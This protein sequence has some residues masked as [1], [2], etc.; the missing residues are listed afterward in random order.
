M[1]FRVSQGFARDI[2][3]AH[4]TLAPEDPGGDG[5]PLVKPVMAGRHGPAPQLIRLPSLQ[6]ETQH[7]I[8]MLGK[9]RAAG[10][11][12]HQMAVLYAAPFIGEKVA[13]AFTAAGIPL[14]WLKDS[15]SKR[16]NASHPSI[17]LMHLKSSNG[18]EF[19]VVAIA[20]VGHLP[21]ES[22]VDD[23]RLL[24]VGMTRATERLLMT[25]SRTS[26]FVERLRD[27]EQAA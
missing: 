18:L 13:A 8:H 24:Y 20:G 10:T 7:L 3:F 16:Y 2:L 1:F 11:L 21:Y 25:A 17:K 12:W 5:V 15:R 26:D 4:G 27:F 19:P 9:M 6:A 23:A 14:E 22:P